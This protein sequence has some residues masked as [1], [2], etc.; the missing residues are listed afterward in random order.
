MC[1][2]TCTLLY[3][4][5]LP[6]LFVWIMEPF[7][8][9]TV[10]RICVNALWNVLWECHLALFQSFVTSSSHQI[11]LKAESGSSFL[12][13]SSSRFPRPVGQCSDSLSQVYWPPCNL[14]GPPSTHSSP[15]SPELPDPWTFAYLLSLRKVLPLTLSAW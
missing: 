6:K 5:F 8:S 4:L 14:A 13:F 1:V 11:L 3:I 15:G 7:P 12:S 9:R 10:L 2:Y